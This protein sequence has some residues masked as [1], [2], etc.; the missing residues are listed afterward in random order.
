MDYK[1]FKLTN[2]S[3]DD[4]TIFYNNAKKE[5][6]K[7]EFKTPLLHLPF[8]IDKDK[9]MNYY[10]NLQLRKTNCNN[11]NHELTLFLKFL[12][13]IESFIKTETGKEVQSVI[14][15]TYKFDTIIN[16]KILKNYNKITT[17]IFK[18]KEHFNF[19]KLD[20]GMNLKAQLII[21]KIWEYNDKIFYKLKIQKLFLESV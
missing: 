12:E 11:H 8:G 10:L 21:D 3:L 4:N 13:S 19:F 18:D 1:V 7:F 20:S 15:K 16:T 17:D 2:L 5:K 14:R 6:K 9:K